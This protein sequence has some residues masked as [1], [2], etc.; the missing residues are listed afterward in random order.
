MRRCVISR[1]ESWQIFICFFST[2]KKTREYTRAWYIYS[3]LCVYMRVNVRVGGFVKP[4]KKSP[5]SISKVEVSINFEKPE[6][7][8]E[9][10]KARVWAG[11]GCARRRSTS[12]Q[13]YH[14]IPP[15]SLYTYVLFPLV[16]LRNRAR[17]KKKRL[18]LVYRST[19]SR[20]WRVSFF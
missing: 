6:K 8:T 2:K 14:I 4:I 12:S 9:W 18:L 20:I 16:Y 17:E 3:R 1:K 13:R 15:H 19:F 5:Y 11:E 10:K 7:I